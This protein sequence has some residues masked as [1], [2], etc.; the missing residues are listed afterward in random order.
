MDKGAVRSVEVILDTGRKGSRGD[1]MKSV[2]VVVVDMVR[3]NLEMKDMEG[4]R[5]V[6]GPS[7]MGM[8]DAP[9]IGGTRI[10]KIGR[11]GNDTGAAVHVEIGM[12]VGG[13]AIGIVS[14]LETTEIGQEIEGGIDLSHCSRFMTLY[15]RSSIHGIASSPVKN[16]LQSSFCSSW[17][18]SVMVCSS[19]PELRY[20]LYH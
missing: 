15:I 14:V 7:D 17:L 3:I 19:E 12:I 2:V 6:I 5:G 8:T 18:K 1:L 11:I 16:I 20:I 9:T 10:E 13:G 4:G